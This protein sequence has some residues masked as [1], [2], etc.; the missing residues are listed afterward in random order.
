MKPN[1]S[2]MPTLQA[3]DH[4]DLPEANRLADAFRLR[5][6]SLGK[7]FTELLAYAFYSGVRWEDLSD[8]ERLAFLIW[9]EGIRG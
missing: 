2:Q 8:Q 7:A 5:L 3:L 9:Q 1:F 6:E 4:P